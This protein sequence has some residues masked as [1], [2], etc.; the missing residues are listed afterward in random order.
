MTNDF[1]GL[2]FDGFLMLVFFTGI[3]ILAGFIPS[4]AVRAILVV[5]GIAGIYAS[6]L[7]GAPL[8]I[9]GTIALMA[10]V[11]GTF[12]VV[13]TWKERTEERK[14]KELEGSV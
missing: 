10:I 6:W 8:T 11:V 5:L 13:K 14:K 9:K 12:V 7:T 3:I 4:R 2:G 1:Y